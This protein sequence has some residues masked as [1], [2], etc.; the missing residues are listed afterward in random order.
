[1]CI[2]STL[3][4][5]FLFIILIVD[6]ACICMYT[7]FISFDTIR[8][9]GALQNSEDFASVFKCPSDSR[10]NPKDKCDLW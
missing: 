5:V 7:A 9:I 8:I 3:L 10:M 4:N 2:I 1:M 6:N